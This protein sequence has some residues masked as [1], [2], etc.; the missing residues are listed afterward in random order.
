MPRSSL[1]AGA[2]LVLALAVP[3]RA[4]L[5]PP[6]VNIRWDHCYDDGGALNRAFACDTNA[7]SERLVLS[8]A[9]DADK[10]NVSG[11]E[12]VVD[13]RTTDPAL[14][15]WWSF[16]NVGT[17][18]Q[19]SLGY[20]LSV[21][22]GSA[23]CQD[24]AGGQAAGGI[25]AYNIGVLGPTTA[26]IVAAAAVPSSS[27]ATLAAGT[28]YFVIQFTINHAKTVG[29]GACAG[30]AEPVCIVL[31]SIHIASV[32]IADDLKLMKGA[33]GTDSQYVHWQGASVQDLHLSC[34]SP[35]RPCE[36]LYSCVL[37]STPVRGSTWGAVKSLYR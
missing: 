28:E 5:S 34:P 31:S 6:G 29:T 4:A 37:A 11:Q 33:N 18:R 20:S 14:P 24:W 35:F 1:L 25:G 32:N 22:P 7:G 21:P 36:V 2:A 17:C 30:C 16:K 26:R 15:S 13:L 23:N 8:F 9:L 27:L 12:I 3:A 10:S 19:A